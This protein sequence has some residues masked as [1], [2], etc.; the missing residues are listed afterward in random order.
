MHGNDTTLS[1]GRQPGLPI[2]AATLEA[3]EACVSRDR[4]APYHLSPADP[5]EDIVARYLW[6]ASLCEALYPSL[7][8][9]EVALRNT[10]FAAVSSWHGRDDWVAGG[11]APFLHVPERNAIRDLAAVRARMRQPVDSPHMVAALHL[12][13]WTGLLDVRYERTQ[14]L[15]PRLLKAAFPG[16][17]R[18]LRTRAN[19]A[20]RFD[21]VRRL[22]NRVF[23]QEPVWNVPDLAAKHASVVEALGWV[24]PPVRDLEAATDRFAAVHGDGPGGILGRL[25]GTVP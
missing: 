10:L 22:R 14:T 15:W 16:M 12:G 21:A 24:S 5:P 13:F 25:Q 19:A 20:G 3:L 2:D 1:T 11:P 18:R 7:H 23:H 8:H 6:N 17:P 9:A 4:L